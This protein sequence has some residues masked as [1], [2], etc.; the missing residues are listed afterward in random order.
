ML[1]QRGQ[2]RAAALLL[3]LLLLSGCYADLDWRELKSTEGGFKVLMPARA[4]ENT[5]PMGTGAGNA[6]LTLWTAEAAGAVFGAG[7]ADYPDTAGGAAS[8]LATTRD[9]LVRNVRGKVTSEQAVRTANLHGRSLI[10]EGFAADGSPR[11]VHARLYASGR[12]LYELAVIARPGALTEADLE[13]FFS[14]FTPD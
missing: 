6:T 12:R 8:H 11:V 2:S 14:S 9:G 1:G 7:Y 10:I 13:M 3:S 4:N 5:G